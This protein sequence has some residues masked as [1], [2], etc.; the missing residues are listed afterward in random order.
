MP[1]PTLAQTATA[2]APGAP[3][4]PTTCAQFSAMP[5]TDQIAALSSIEPLGGELQS[6]DP[7][8]AAQWAAAVTSACDGHPDRAL[9]DAAAEA[10]SGN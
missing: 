10:L 9:S 6:S 7:T 1:W 2:P 4:G 8:I 3:T 5:S